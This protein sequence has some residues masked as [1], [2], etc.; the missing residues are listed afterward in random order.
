[1][2]D[3]ILCSGTVDPSLSSGP[4]QPALTK[5]GLKVGIIDDE[6]YIMQC[7]WRDSVAERKTNRSMISPSGD[8]TPFRVNILIYATHCFLNLIVFFLLFLPGSGSWPPFSS[9]ADRKNII[10]IGNRGQWVVF[11]QK[12]LNFLLRVVWFFYLFFQN[13]AICLFILYYK[14]KP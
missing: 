3:L 5:E 13:I 9:P 10:K 4:P 8:P 6:I 7:Q 11:L 1:M 12:V 2:P 14:E